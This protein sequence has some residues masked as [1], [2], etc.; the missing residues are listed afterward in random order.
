MILSKIYMFLRAIVM[1]FSFCTQFVYILYAFWFVQHDFFLL[2]CLFKQIL[3]YR[4]VLADSCKVK[5][6]FQMTFS[7]SFHSKVVSFTRIRMTSCQQRS[8]PVLTLKMEKSIDRSII[9]HLRKTHRIIRRPEIWQC[10]K[11]CFMP[12]LRQ[13]W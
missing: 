8:H 10:H 4:V 1:M 5:A 3:R 9:L 6:R 11:P 13:F 7:D 12:M 2:F